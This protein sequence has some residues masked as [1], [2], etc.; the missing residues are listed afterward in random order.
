MRRN[1]NVIQINGIKGIIF[2]IGA[3][4]CLIAGFVGFPG[5]LMKSGWNLMASSTGIVP[6]IGL[7]QGMLLWGI[8]VVS[9]FVLRGKKSWLVEFK[10]ADDLSQDEMDAVMKR[11]RM[12]RQSD[13]IAKSIM[14]ARELEL[15][16]KQELDNKLKENIDKH[17]DNCIDNTIE[18]QHT[19]IK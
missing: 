7:I 16:A 19:E 13:L 10:S 8:I 2:C 6:S 14:R 4:I 3:V 17:I 1:F 9:Y 18:K 5:I 15:K 12:E 11:I